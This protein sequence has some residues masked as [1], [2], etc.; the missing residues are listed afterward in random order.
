MLNS[1]FLQA[2]FDEVDTNS[3][4][5]ISRDV[6]AMPHALQNRRDDYHLWLLPC[7]L[8]IPS[9]SSSGIKQLEDSRT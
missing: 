4:G 2:D 6:T 9:S 3:D 8:G 7:S 1:I 5:V